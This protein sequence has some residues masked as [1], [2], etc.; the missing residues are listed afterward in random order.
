MLTSNYIYFVQ[1]VRLT[2]KSYNLFVKLFTSNYIRDIIYKND[3]QGRFIMIISVANQKGGVAKTT[4]AFTISN[5]LADHKKSVLM[6]DLDPQASLSLCA[7]IDKR[8]LTRSMYQVMCEDGSIQ[9]SIIKNICGK[10]NL[11]LAPSSGRLSNADIKLAS[12]AGRENI[13]SRILGKIKHQYDFIIIDTS[14][15]L[16]LLVTN[17]LIASHSIL[18]PVCADNLSYEGLTDL[19]ETLDKIKE[20]LNQSL[21]ILGTVITQYDKRTLHSREAKE[22]LEKNYNVIAT[23]PISTQVKDATL[24]GK[25]ISDL[26]PSHEI[27]ENYKKVTEVILNAK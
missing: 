6:I 9:D 18:I 2:I 1:T 7:G 16:S 26:N 21:N 3:I 25:S 27:T 11:H 22:F 24:I 19:F 4:T 14:P 8:K 23:I 15:A 5:I 17:A 12:E 13:L 10:N 20:H